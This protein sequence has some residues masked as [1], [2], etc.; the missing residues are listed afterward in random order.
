M[1]ESNVTDEVTARVEAEDG[2][3]GDVE[4]AGETT[5][6]AAITGPTETKP[7]GADT[8]LKVAGTPEREQEDDGESGAK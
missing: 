6:V 2:G 8:M 1:K 5:A 7:V 4:T 3:V